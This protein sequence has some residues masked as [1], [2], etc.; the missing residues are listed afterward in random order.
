MSDVS[1]LHITS[2]GRATHPAA[3]SPPKLRLMKVGYYAAL[4][5]IAAFS[6][7]WVLWWLL[8]SEP[9]DS[10]D[11]HY[12]DRL[13]KH[14]PSRFFR[15]D[16]YYGSVLIYQSAPFII[17]ALLSLV[18]VELRKKLN[19]S[20]SHETEKGISK[21]SP[22]L[23][24]YPLVIKSFMGVLTSAD[25]LFILGI[26]FLVAYTFGRQ[27]HL[28]FQDLEREYKENPSEFDDSLVIIKFAYAAY[29]MGRSAM[30]PFSLLWI[31]VSR[32]SPFLR[33]INMPFEH[34]VKYHIWLSMLSLFMLTLHGILYIVYYVG[35]DEAKAII[36]WYVEGET[37]SV[38]AGV[39]A[40]I[41]GLLMWVTSLSFFRRRWYEWFF[42]IHHLYIVFFVFWLYHV[43]W[44][45]HFFIIPCLL[46]VV[47]RFLR[48]VQSQQSVD[49]LSA[50]LLESGSIEIKFAKSST[51]GLLY[52]ALSSWYL[53]FSSLSNLM[54]L[55]WHFFSVTS[56]EMDE[57]EE[58]SIIIKPLGKWTTLLRE[59][60]VKYAKMGDN[61]KR[62]HCPFTFKAGVEGPYG[63][64]SN[65]FLEYKVL[66]L[67]GGG[68][69]VTP[70]LALLRDVFTQI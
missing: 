10:P 60:I 47:D 33:L 3:P 67:V 53:R 55:Q 4:L 41:A 12:L 26:L 57:K 17:V 46:F 66:I 30:I 36:S 34:A 29:Y 32:G 21:S 40:T 48:M 11:G 43:M 7:M 37:Y 24:T 31:P 61:V 18:V 5:G 28:S 23:T 62:N 44:T 50:K 27:C 9:A 65:F 49:V 70:L 58:L 19:S 13:D 42:G 25:V 35:A 39:I 16:G 54:K 22:S 6:C 1:G 59:K 52:Y 15:T 8:S 56:T 38:L 45:I 51:E 14:I 64:E 20:S 69:G 63:D 2:D 68:I